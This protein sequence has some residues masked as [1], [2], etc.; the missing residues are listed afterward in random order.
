MAALS[1]GNQQKLVVGREMA[2]RPRLMLAAQPT[3]GLDVGA[4][5][6]VHDELRELRDEGCGVL[7]VSLDLSEVLAVSDRVVVMRNGTVVG[8]VSAT[9]VDMA[10]LGAWMT[11]SRVVGATP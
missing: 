10:M 7:L 1:G 8:A 11:G 2:R 5:A 3:R 6:F 9:D 4:T